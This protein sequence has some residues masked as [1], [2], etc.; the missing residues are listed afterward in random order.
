MP[1]T[2]SATRVRFGEFTADMVSQELFR[3]GTLVRL[4]NQ[5]FVALAAL[6]ERPGE[7]VTREQ[8]RARVWPDD[9][10][11]EFE[12]GLNAVINRLREALGDDAEDPKYVETLP[13]RGYRFVA[14]VES[15]APA[16]RDV[17]AES[18]APESLQAQR[19]FPW[20]M[21]LAIVFLA[22]AAVLAFWRLRL[23]PESE[24]AVVTPLTS[25]VGEERSPALSPDGERIAFAWNGESPDLPG[26]DLYV[27]PVGS[28]RH[29]RLTQA[30]AIA[31]SAA[32]SPDGTELAFARNSASN[33]GVFLIAA[34]GGTERK[35]VGAAFAQE[36]LS[37][38]AWSPDGRTLAYS[39]I[40]AS[41][42]QSLRLLT[43]DSLESRLLANTPSRWHAGAPTW[44]PDGKHLA[45]IC[46]TSIAV[47]GVYLTE[48]ATTSTPRLLAKLQG[49]PQGLA[50]DTERARLLV[51]N[52]SG[53]GGGV[54]ELD[55]D[56]TLQRPKI[57]ED[58]IAS[59][60]SAAQG[61]LVYSRSRQLINIW[62]VTR[63]PRL[64][65]TKRWIFSTRQQL[66][67]QFSPDETRIAFQSNRSGTPEIWI[68]DADGGNA[69]R[70]TSFDGPLTGAPAWCADGRRL[71]FDSRS[72]N[73]P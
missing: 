40:D 1:Q 2:P 31:V 19:G 51:A 73:Y 69:V 21:S 6:L 72:R 12:Q 52:D 18:L 30:P 64:T 36:S 50:W 9:R 38:P 26:F 42:S 63:E 29:M 25:L 33:G 15:A 17:T 62:R 53:D 65:R 3:S 67:P 48:P 61:R 16:R 58:A 68:V 44:S 24:V 59:G 56:G 54:W 70:I 47:Y 41:G 46:M 7:L 11:V 60:V 39:A 37:R 66:T 57:A 55:L 22:A 71:A 13:R 49:F 32:W 8:L 23:P 45:F 34:T 5:S 20:L 14:A 10:V 4:P 27:K 28:E 35:L 43:L